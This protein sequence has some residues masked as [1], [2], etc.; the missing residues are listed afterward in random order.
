VNYATANVTALAGKDYTAEAGSVSFAPGV[1]SQSVSI[2]VLPGTMGESSVTFDVNLSAATGASLGTAQ[3]VGTIKVPG[4]TTG[5]KN[6]VWTRTTGVSVSGNSLTKTAAAAWGNAGP[7]STQYLVSGDG[8]VQFTASELTT[9]R[10]LG[11]THA[12]AAPTYMDINFGLLPAGN[13]VIYVYENGV[14]INTF[15]AYKTGD[16][17][18]VQ[19]TGG[20]VQYARNGSVFYTSA[21]APAYPLV[22]GSALYN[23]GA[24]LMNAVI[25]GKLQ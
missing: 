9:S 4:T 5:T 10:V 17:L 1:T 11:L 14:F 19:V 21:L 18:K 16:L 13:G 7:L 8:Y 25:S 22:A 15:G 20:V 24:T 6:I 3:G 2:P 23:Q 12:D